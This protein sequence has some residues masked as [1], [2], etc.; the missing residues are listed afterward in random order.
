MYTRGVV[1]A[2]SLIGLAVLDDWAGPLLTTEKPEADETN[3]G[4][5]PFPGGFSDGTAGSADDAATGV[6]P[7]ALHRTDTA[8]AGKDSISQAYHKW[9]KFRDSDSDSDLD[10]E[11]LDAEDCRIN[12]VQFDNINYYDKITMSSVLRHEEETKLRPEKG[13]LTHYLRH[14]PNHLKFLKRFGRGKWQGHG[15]VPTKI[16]LFD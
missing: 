3:N 11:D 12:G 6:V 13:T 7:Q 8:P 14:C 2:V 1:G 4:I 16:P 9:D 10:A 5:A 15:P